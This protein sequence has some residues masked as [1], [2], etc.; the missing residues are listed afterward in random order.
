MNNTDREFL[1]TLTE[2]LKAYNINASDEQIQKLCSFNDMVMST[3]SHTNLTAIVTGKESAQKHFLDSLNPQA[4]KAVC[5]TDNVIDVG[6][7]AGFPGIP[8]SVMNPGVNF[9]LLDTRK[10]RCEFMESVK[11]KLKLENVTVIWGRAEELGKLPQYR[12]RYQ[13]SCAR[14]LAAMPVLLEYLAPF[15]KIGGYAMLYKGSSAVEDIASAKNAADVLGF[16]NF[17]NLPYSLPKEDAK[18][19]M[20]KWLKTNETPERYP[21]KPGIALKRPL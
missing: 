4:M 21:R 16:G 15:I 6:S 1:T 13:I 7:G 17:E 2:G 12:N 10:K 14:A 20:V 5:E 19:H 18:L 9:T 11:Y 8:L 3:N